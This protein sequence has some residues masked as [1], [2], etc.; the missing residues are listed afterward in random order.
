MLKQLKDQ[1]SFYAC[2][3]CGLQDISGKVIRESDL[4]ELRAENERLRKLLGH[5]VS[6][7]LKDFCDW[8]S[9]DPAR[10]EFLKQ[11]CPELI[12]KYKKFLVKIIKK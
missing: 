2:M 11:D 3:D 7:W 9:E 10:I 6:I 1:P 8:L 5:W 12:D 4:S